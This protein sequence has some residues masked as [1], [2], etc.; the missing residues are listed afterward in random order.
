[1]N[2][3]NQSTQEDRI[4]AGFMGGALGDAL[5]EPVEFLSAEAR[6]DRWGAQG[7]AEF[8]HPG[9]RGH[10]TDDTQMTLFTAE[11]LILHASTGEPLQYTLHKAYMRWLLTQEVPSRLPAEQFSSEGFLLD[12]LVLH[13]RR[14]PGRTCLIALAQAMDWGMPA[15]NDSKGCGGLMRVAPIGF[16]AALNP[17]YWPLQR[18][19]Q[20]ASSAAQLTHGHVCGYLCAGAFAVLLQE[21]ILDTPLDEALLLLMDILSGLGE[22]GRKILQAL[23]QAKDLAEKGTDW[24]DACKYLGAGWVAEEILAIAVYL[25][26]T[27]PDFLTGIRWAANHPGDAD[28]VGAISGQ[29]LGAIWGI[30]AIP[31]DWT[32][33]LEGNEIIDSLVAHFFIAAKR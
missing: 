6:R 12:A 33:R 4:W 11:A 2:Q 10:F 8:A 29:L 22:T 23:Q 18:T 30:Q 28:S 14:G 17:E 24:N 16:W 5:G 13:Q 27:T 26:M 3:I 7:V 1:M 31:E 19:F 25:G 32:E 21:I 20:V 9:Q 15:I